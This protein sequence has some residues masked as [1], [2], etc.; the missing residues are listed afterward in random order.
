MFK[1]AENKTIVSCLNYHAEYE[2]NDLGVLTDVNVWRDNDSTVVIEGKVNNIADVR[3]III[4]RNCD[5]KVNF[6]L[7]TRYRDSVTVIREAMVAFFDVPVDEVYLKNRQMDVAR[8]HREYWLDK[9]GFKIG[10]GS[11]S[12]MIY[13]PVGISSLQLATKKKLA[14]INLESQF[15]HPFITIPFQ[16]D[17][18]GIWNDISAA[19][20]VAGD[21]R[22][23]SFSVLVGKVPDIVPRLMLL[24]NGYLAGY[25][26]TE[27]ADSGS[28]QTHRAAYFG[29]ETITDISNATGGFAG[30]NIPV[31]KSI[32][33]EEFDDGISKSPGSDN[34]S[35]SE[36]LSFLD[37]LYSSGLYDLCLHTPENTNSDRQYLEEAI[38]LM[39]E[40]YNSG[41][42]IDHGMY[43]GNT[44]RESFVADG[45]N[46]STEYYAADL[47]SKYGT[48]Y[49]WS[50]AVEAIRFSKPGFS[51]RD[52][53]MHL[54][55]RSLSTEL[56][57]RYD[58]RKSYFG[59]NSVTSLLK[60]LH[61]SFPMFELNSFQRLGTTALPTPLYW[62]NRTI[63]GSFY[64][65]TTE[66]VYN[67][68]AVENPEKWVSTEK[69]GLDIL[70]KD[71]GIFINHGY[72]IRNSKKNRVLTH[73]DGKQVVSPEFD[74]ILSYMDSLRFNGDLWITTIKDIMNYW[75]MT[76]NISFE[77]TSDG[78]VEISN[79]ND[80][81]I[82]GLSL[83]VRAKKDN[84][85]LDGVEPFSKQA[86]DDTVLWFDIPAKGKRVLSIH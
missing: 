71:R 47:W 72:Y 50:P 56:R 75:L 27:H 36:Y 74:E 10:D 58:Y 59:E 33:Y 43:Q 37:Q 26:F 60:L 30:H 77:Y 52:E 38:I 14:F 35:E 66:Y 12:F 15:D 78:S 46:P 3:I 9:E 16:K 82:K 19:T 45:L 76:E 83:A 21:E 29:S 80:I 61:G 73:V 51:L 54:R 6:T 23:D 17:G 79:F 22:T 42:W 25:V 40:R 64:S 44:N 67:G 68:L 28:I 8:F 84:L 81:A 24:P 63:A 7:T 70:L 13:R 11:R 69:I 53:L 34:M 2:K 5:P 65:W 48:R 31:T 4:V 55:F 18:G 20:Y 49:F 39:K 57:K 86:G 32:F 1:S 85:K 62:Q 41:T